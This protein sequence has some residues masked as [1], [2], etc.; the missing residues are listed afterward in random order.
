[1]AGHV[2]GLARACAAAVMV[3][4]LAAQAQA[5]DLSD[6]A[7]RKFFNDRGCNACHGVEE[8]RIGQPYRLVAARYAGASADIRE[9][10]SWKIRRGGAGAWGVVPMISNP[11]VSQQEADAVVRW[12]LGLE[13]AERAA[14]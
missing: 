1:M 10:L 5:A 4:G 13:A 9:A 12:I 2:V 8:T 3:I 11:G 6:T 14:R 7:A